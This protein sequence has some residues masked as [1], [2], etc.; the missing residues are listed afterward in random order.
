MF[1]KFILS[2]GDQKLTNFLGF[3]FSDIIF[4]FIKLSK[5]CIA[6]LLNT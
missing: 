5:Y 6:S 1:L 3:A 4:V 2:H